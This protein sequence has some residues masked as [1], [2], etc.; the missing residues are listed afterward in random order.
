[1]VCN[2]C[3]VKFERNTAVTV[4][5]LEMVVAEFNAIVADNLGSIKIDVPET[6]IEREKRGTHP[7]LMH[8][9]ESFRK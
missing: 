6:T 1:M 3:V 9:A 2:D 7:S 5:S 4:S 8:N